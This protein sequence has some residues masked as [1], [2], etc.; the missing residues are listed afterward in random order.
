M[1]FGRGFRWLVV[2]ALLFFAIPFVAATTPSGGAPPQPAQLSTLPLFQPQQHNVSNDPAHRFGENHVAVNPTNPNNL[3]A[4]YN[5]DP[6]TLSCATSGGTNGECQLVTAHLLNLGVPLSFPEPKGDFASFG[7]IVAPPKFSTCGVFTSFD[8]GATWQH[9]DI[10]GWPSDKPWLKDQGDCSVTVQTDGSFYVSFDDLDWNDPSNPTDNAAQPACGIGVDKSTDGG[11]TWTGSVL[12]GTSCDGPK[13][14]AD[15]NDGRVYGTSSGTLGARATGVPGD[16]LVNGPNDRYV[17][18]TTDGTSWT[19]P[20]GLGGQDG[21]TYRAASGGTMSAA[22]GTVAV[23]FRQTTNAACK[24]FVGTAAPC[25]V[26]E[27]STDAGAA[28]V[29]HAVTNA[30]NTLLASQ[31]T[32]ADPSTPG[33]Y[34]VAGLN[35]SNQFVTFQTTDSGATWSGPG[36]P[37]IDPAT[38]GKF[39]SWINYSSTGIL[40]LTWSANQGSGTG[41]TQ[42]PYKVYAA[43]SA[44]GGTTWM[45]HGSPIE[46]S[47]GASPAGQTC[48]SFCAVSDDYSNISLRPDVAFVTWA[49]W[50]GNTGCTMPCDRAGYLSAV[51]FLNYT[52]GGFLP[53]VQNRATF[54]A[55]SII[56]VKFHLSVKGQNAFWASATV[57]IDGNLAGTFRYDPTAQQYLFNAST[58]GLSTGDHTLIV[59]LDDDTTY[60][61]N[62]TLK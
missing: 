10:P 26:F 20:H 43:F 52:F 24:F 18:A 41:A 13:I 31:M 15:P 8:R 38:F 49:D 4:I 23:A 7:P 55:G 19:T 30:G 34:T 48:N 3:V 22:N 60:S 59:H 54:Q 51:R 58:K 29:R 46:V 39:H 12:T 33:H 40:G 36:A 50:R 25:I 44:D 17:A 37:I 53:P 61:V 35:G 14:I 45:N 47:N 28:W 6:Y 21:G 56:P 2:L 1:P 16:P 57:S 27:Y 11:L 9:V 42:S 62:V 5:Q 32:A